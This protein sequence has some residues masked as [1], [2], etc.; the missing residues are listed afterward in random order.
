MRRLDLQPCVRRGREGVDIAHEK[1]A[2]ELQG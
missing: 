2:G 1:N